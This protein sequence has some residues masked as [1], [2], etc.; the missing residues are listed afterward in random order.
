MAYRVSEILESTIFDEWFHVS[1]GE[2]PADTGN[3]GITAKALKKSGWVKVPRF[4]KTNDWPFKPDSEPL[5]S[6]RKKG[7]SYDLNEG[8]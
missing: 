3:R 1:S 8:I 4:L 7:S 2:N 5:T 6:L